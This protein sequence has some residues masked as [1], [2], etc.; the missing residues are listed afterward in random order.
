MTKQIKEASVEAKEVAPEAPETVE[1]DNRV[2]VVLDLPP[3][4][5]GAIMHAG[6][7]YLPNTPYKVSPEVARD[8]LEAQNRCKAHEASLHEN[9]NKH[10]RTMRAFA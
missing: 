5:G 4:A 8:L 7:M 9:E 10:R 6:V 3:A 1:V 2:T